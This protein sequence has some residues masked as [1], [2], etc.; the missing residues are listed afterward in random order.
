MAIIYQTQLMGEAHIRVALVSRGEADLLVHRA[1]SR[2]L[3]AGD[4][5]WFITRDKQEASCYVFFTSV[6]MA[7]VT[8]SFVDNYGEAGWQKPSRYKNRFY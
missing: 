5:Q 4:G 2:G 1:S 8:V 6:G 3:A 7:Q